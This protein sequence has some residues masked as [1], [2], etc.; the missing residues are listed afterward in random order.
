MN[1]LIEDVLET[2]GKIPDDL[3]DGIWLQAR[4]LAL[5]LK[6]QSEFV[7]AAKEYVDWGFDTTHA[8]GEEHYKDYNSVKEALSKLIRSE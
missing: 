6:A 8:Y 4:D 2:T 7:E 3:L 5:M 1:D